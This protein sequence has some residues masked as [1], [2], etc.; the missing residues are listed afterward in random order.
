MISIVVINYNAVGLFNTLQS[1]LALKPGDYE[2]LV[3]DGLSTDGSQAI[4]RDIPCVDQFVSEP[5][6]GIYSAMNKGVRLARGD[7][8]IFMNSGDAFYAPDSLDRFAP[9]LAEADIIY[10]LA[11]GRRSGKVR[12]FNDHLYKGMAFCHQATLQRRSLLERL[13]FNEKRKIVA[14]YE[15]FVR[16]ENDGARFKAIDDIIALVD[17]DGVSYKQFYQRTFERFPIAFKHYD[18]RKVIS[19]FTRLVLKR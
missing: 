14:D 7:W 5:D 1:V 10:G 17:E 18:K 8:V 3:I 11:K 15:F 16:A 19:H 13:P 2:T 4:A 9:H 6:G 12:Q